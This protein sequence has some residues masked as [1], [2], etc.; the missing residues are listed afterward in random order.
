[1]IC[2]HGWTRLRTGGAV[3]AVVS[4]AAASAGCASGDMGRHAQE[5]AVRGGTTGAM[6]GAVIGFVNALLS[7]GDPAEAAFEGAVWGG[8]T[9]A[10]AGA[11]AGSEMDRRERMARE[12]RLEEFHRQ[13]GEECFAG[14]MALIECWHR[15]ALWH[16]K[17]ARK[18]GGAEERLAALWLE[19]LVR[20]DQ[21]RQKKLEALLPTLVEMD[22]EIET[23]E[24]AREAVRIAQ[25]DLQD[26][27]TSFGLPPVCP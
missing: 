8:A 18:K 9:G 2:R 14:W 16:V 19:I 1:M 12:A 7:G 15:E 20:A 22:P 5:E 24:R 3:L 25:V 21:H 4:L 27:R 11:A 17:R 23:V 6:M 10:A 26:L 13:V